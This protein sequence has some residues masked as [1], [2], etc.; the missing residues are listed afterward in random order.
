[1]NNTSTSFSSSDS[2]NFR[3]FIRCYS[4]LLCLSGIPFFW[5][6]SLASLSLFSI[7]F[8]QLQMRMCHPDDDSD[9]SDLMICVQWYGATFYYNF[10]QSSSCFVSAFFLFFSFWMNV[11]CQDGATRQV[12]CM[13]P[14]MKSC[15]RAL[16]LQPDAGQAG[17][18]TN[19]TCMGTEWCRFVFTLLK[20][21]HVMRFFFFL[22]VESIHQECWKTHSICCCH[23]N[24]P[25]RRL[26]P[27]SSWPWTPDW[28][29]PPLRWS[30][31]RLQEPNSES[32]RRLS[33]W[34]TH[35][36]GRKAPSREAPPH[37]WRW[38]NCWA[39]PGWWK[40]AYPWHSATVLV[41]FQPWIFQNC[42]VVLT[43]FFAFCSSFSSRASINHHWI[44]PSSPTH[45]CCTRF[46]RR[47]R[48]GSTARLQ[49]FKRC[50]WLLGYLLQ[51]GMLWFL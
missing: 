31:A 12:P 6:L 17:A 10:P 32:R 25:T 37:C 9:E 26:C 38:T 20:S 45:V 39:M 19:Q 49:L 43:F 14:A 27:R 28:H 8:T 1:M 24:R 36:R 2:T 15:A 23:C 33:G 34:S 50:S 48:C 40:A 41:C 13:I 21:V 22:F 11:F 51:L 29:G 44:A 42:H 4:N 35:V 16:E 18:G 5:L 3:V 47:P 7:H 46:R 30:K